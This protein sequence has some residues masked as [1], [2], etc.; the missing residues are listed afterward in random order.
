MGALVL[1][2]LI[3]LMNMQQN[4]LEMRSHRGM[5]RDCNLNPF[6]RAALLQAAPQGAKDFLY[7][8]RGERPDRQHHRLVWEQLQEGLPSPA[9]GG[10]VSRTHHQMPTL[11]PTRYLQ[12]EE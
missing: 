12:Q 10:V 3:S 7:L 4:L 5:N 1:M 11:T 8:H 2:Q 9:E 6:S